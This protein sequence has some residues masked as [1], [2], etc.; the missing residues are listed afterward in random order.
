MIQPQVNLLV[1]VEFEGRVDGIMPIMPIMRSLV[2]VER[3]NLPSNCECLTLV[4]T[5]QVPSWVLTKD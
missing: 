1:V 2:L 3:S 4:M 5:I